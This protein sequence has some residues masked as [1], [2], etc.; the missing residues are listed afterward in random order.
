[1]LAQTKTR[2]SSY[3]VLK[4]T[5]GNKALFYAHTQVCMYYMQKH[6]FLKK[7]FPSMQTGGNLQYNEEN[8][9]A[10]IPNNF[11]PLGNKIYFCRVPVSTS[12]SQ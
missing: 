12:K 2:S 4:V 9:S 5:A 6:C 10:T 11:L 3:C 8:V 1:M 7:K